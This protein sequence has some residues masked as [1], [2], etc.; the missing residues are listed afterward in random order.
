MFSYNNLPSYNNKNVHAVTLKE[1]EDKVAQYTAELKEK[2]AKS[3]E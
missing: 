1:Y 2:E 3:Q